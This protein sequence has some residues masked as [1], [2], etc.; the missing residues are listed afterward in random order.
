MIKVE[1]I[2]IEEFR[3]I[4]SLQLELNNESY[5]ICGPNG[6]GKSG[7]VDAVEFALTGSI[8]RLTGKGRGALSVLKHGPH[9]D[10]RKAPEKACVTLEVSIATLGGKKATITRDVKSADIPIITPDE[11]AVRAAVEQFEKHPEFVLSR[12]E[13][14]KYVLAEPGER[15]QEVQAVLQLDELEKARVL[16]QKISNACTRETAP[17]MQDEQSAREAL[18]SAMDIAELTPDSILAAA[19]EKRKVLGLPPLARLET[20]TSLKDGLESL[21][22][23]AASRVPKEAARADIAKAIEATR[24]LAGADIEKEIQAATEAITKL[25][26]NE[27]SLENVTRESMLR[28]AIDLFDEHVCPVCA[29]EWNPEHFRSIV[30]TQMERLEAAVKERAAAEKLLAPIIKKLE[31]I[32]T[33]IKSAASYGPLFVPPIETATLNEYGV[34][35][36]EKASTLRKFLPLT[37]VLAA[38]TPEVEGTAKALEALEEMGRAVEAIPDPNARDGARDF[39]VTADERLRAYR[40]AAAKYNAAKKKSATAKHTFEIF[41]VA[42]NK[43]LEDI[44]KQVE[45]QFRAFYRSLNQDESAFEATLTPLIGKLDFDVG[46]FGRGSFPPGAYH[47]EGHQDA[48]GLCLYLALMKHILGEGFTLAVLDDVLMSVDRAHRREVCHLLTKQFPQVQFVLTTHDPVWLRHMKTA[49]LIRGK[50]GVEFQSWDVD[51]GP[52]QWKDVDVW[53]EIDSHLSKNNVRE[54]AG[55]LRHHMEYLAAEYCSELGG[56]VDYKGDNH[57]DLGELL[58]GAVSA[59]RDLLKKAKSAANSWDNKDLAKVIDERDKAFNAACEAAFGDQWQVNV[60]IHHNEWADLQKEDFKPV[61]EAFKA[62]AARFECKK[63]KDLLYVTRSGYKKD[64]LRCSCATLSFSLVEK[65]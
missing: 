14:I 39:L 1:K 58:P 10:S 18:I 44:Y 12:R 15:A 53:A 29:T 17:L 64:C 46:F 23:T 28:H 42:T 9:V 26:E 48:M 54:A 13:I 50:A 24:A 38:L 4:R 32:Q 5:A 27:A 22:A 41:G 33:N 40:I 11:P 37:G 16:L 55:L 43:A 21:A 8:S 7:V 3:G 34:H 59:M 65:V 62:L 51:R 2:T 60:V 57:Y 36:A 30:R 63:C 6:T 61:A 45:E 52:T 47:S 56:K 49:G 20:T 31:T 19:N 25:K 35:L